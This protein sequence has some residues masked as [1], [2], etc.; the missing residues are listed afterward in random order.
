M[1][2]TMMTSMRKIGTGTTKPREITCQGSWGWEQGVRVALGK[3]IRF[4][5][6]QP[7]RTKVVGNAQN[8]QRTVREHQGTSVTGHHHKTASDAYSSEITLPP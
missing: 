1:F 2:N 4:G 6:Y 3:G 7:R 8:R 5:S